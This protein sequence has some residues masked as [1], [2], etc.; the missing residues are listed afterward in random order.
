MIEKA[1]GLGYARA[2]SGHAA[3]APP[4]I[5]H[6]WP[7]TPRTCHA[8]RFWT[9]LD[10]PYGARE[11]EAMCDHVWIFEARTLSTKSQGL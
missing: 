1:I 8:A 6:C 3:A 7:G 9:I 2:A 5:V 11:A 4:S 10:G